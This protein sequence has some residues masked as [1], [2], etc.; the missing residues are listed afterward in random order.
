MNNPYFTPDGIEMV[1]YEP[2]R[3]VNRVAGEALGLLRPLDKSERRA[4]S[5]D[6]QGWK[7]ARNPQIIIAG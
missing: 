5:V 1:E 2:H 3:S 7:S 4:Q 6:I